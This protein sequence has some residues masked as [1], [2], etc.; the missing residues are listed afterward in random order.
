MALNDHGKA[1]F[2]DTMSWA[3]AVVGG[4]IS[5]WLGMVSVLLDVGVLWAGLGF[6]VLQGL[7]GVSASIV[8]RGVW[9]E[10]CLVIF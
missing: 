8:S 10:K 3:A 7:L 5:A 9:N 4:A 1:F 2:R 6:C